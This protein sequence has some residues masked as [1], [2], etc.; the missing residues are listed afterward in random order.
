MVIGKGKLNVLKLAEVKGA[1]IRT[2][3]VRLRWS[4]KEMGCTRLHVYA[5]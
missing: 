3:T 1:Y 5:E 2:L 4:E